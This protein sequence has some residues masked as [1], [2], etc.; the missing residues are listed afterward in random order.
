[1]E[2]TGQCAPQLQLPAGS[3]A[4][5]PF[6]RYVVHTERGRSSVLATQPPAYSL[7]GFAL[8][9]PWIHSTISCVKHAT[10]FGESAVLIAAHA[11][12]HSENEP[13]S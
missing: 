11:A 3:F 13:S 10:R 8:K 1:M 6:C 2:F 9:R 5:G 7:G 12:S 4:L